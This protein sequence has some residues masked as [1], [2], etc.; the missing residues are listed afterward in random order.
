MNTYFEYKSICVFT[1]NFLV[2]EVL[3]KMRERK[4]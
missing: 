1:P 2:Y 4:R 3:E